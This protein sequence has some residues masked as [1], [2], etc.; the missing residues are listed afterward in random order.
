MRIPIDEE[1][2]PLPAAIP[3]LPRRWVVER[4]CAWQDVIIVAWAGLR[5]VLSLAAELALLE[6][7]AAGTSF[8]AYDLIIFLTFSVILTTLVGQGSE[9]G[10]PNSLVGRSRR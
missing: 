4:T 8:P 6:L 7:T 10:L 2:E 3:V 5:G 1:P 9:F